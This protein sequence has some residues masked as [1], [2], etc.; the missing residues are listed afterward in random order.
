M[1]KLWRA[2]LSFTYTLQ[3]IQLMVAH[4]VVS[5]AATGVGGQNAGLLS[6]LFGS[7]PSGNRSSVIGTPSGPQHYRLICPRG[8]FVTEIYGWAGTLIDR[9][10]VKC[11]ANSLDLGSTGGFNGAK[12]FTV[13][14]QQGFNA[15]TGMHSETFFQLKFRSPGS[16]SPVQSE[17][18][19]YWS[20][21]VPFEYVCPEDSLLSGMEGTSGSQLNSVTFV[22]DSPTAVEPSL[23][24][25]TLVTGNMW[26]LFFLAAVCVGLYWAVL[27]RRKKQ[28]TVKLTS[29]YSGE[30]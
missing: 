15:V 12:N 11:G 20:L 25:F 1:N 24:V 3:C 2:P 29:K 28:R 5:H 16:E 9:L 17:P 13:S 19:G 21:G 26:I 8:T 27:G 4:L 6:L 10:G 22:C 18:I 14:S 23:D 30:V 7:H